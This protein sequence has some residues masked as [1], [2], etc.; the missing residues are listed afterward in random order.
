MLPPT[1]PLPR[2]ITMTETLA[3][4]RQVF[5]KGNTYEVPENDADEWIRKK[6]ATE[7]RKQK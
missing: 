3:T 6:L 5:L 1:Q 2:R 7:P 4:S